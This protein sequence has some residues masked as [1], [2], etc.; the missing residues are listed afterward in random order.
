MEPDP[1]YVETRLDDA[2][3]TVPDHGPIPAELRS[4]YS[5]LP[6][7]VCLSCELPL[8]DGVFQ[9][10]KAMR[11]EECVHEAAF[12]LPCL[13]EMSDAYSEDSRRTL[14]RFQR[15]VLDAWDPMAC[16]GCGEAAQALERFSRIAV[17]RGT[18]VL[19]PVVLIC[20]K[21]EESIQNSL[22][23]ETRDA[24]DRFLRGHFPGVDAFSS[25]LFA[26]A[27]HRA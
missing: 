16:G 18:S 19:R 6:F 17:C 5:G 27:P 21:C 10:H 13:R 7:E 26:R 20:A 22:S 8:S 24:H 1:R 3:L 15:R 4:T 25:E 11:G 23:T 14:W 12:C 9:I 2:M